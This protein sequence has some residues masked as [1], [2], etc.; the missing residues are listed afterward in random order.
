MEMVPL[1]SSKIWHFTRFG[2]HAA[3]LC[4]NKPFRYISHTEIENYVVSEA[5]VN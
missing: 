1:C 4:Y 3:H 2:L 5:L